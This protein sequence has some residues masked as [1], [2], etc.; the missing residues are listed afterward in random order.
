M[1]TRELRRSSIR[2]RKIEPTNTFEKDFKRELAGKPGKKLDSLLTL[3]F[4]RKKIA[5][6]NLKKKIT[7][8]KWLGYLNRR[9]QRVNA[10]AQVLK[11]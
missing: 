2:M 3:Q 5:L 7:V 8:R 9:L 6:E 10:P 1:N 11:F 4:T